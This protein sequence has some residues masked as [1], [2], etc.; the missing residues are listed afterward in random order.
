MQL[1]VTCSPAAI[2]SGVPI[3]IIVSGCIVASTPP[4]ALGEMAAADTVTLNAKKIVNIKVSAFFICLISPWHYTYVLKIW[5]FSF[6]HVV[7]LDYFVFYV[8]YY[9]I[10]LT[11]PYEI[12]AYYGSQHC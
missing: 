5:N 12:R 9:L 6:F 10:G 4:V 11:S 7:R 1:I 8:C 2:G 3:L